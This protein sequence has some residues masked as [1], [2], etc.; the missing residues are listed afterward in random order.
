MKNRRRVEQAWFYLNWRERTVKTTEGVY[1]TP[2]FDTTINRR[3]FTR[4]AVLIKAGIEQ[5][6]SVG[7]NYD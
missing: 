1:P 2:Q 4:S 6:L 5:V 7:V 3:R